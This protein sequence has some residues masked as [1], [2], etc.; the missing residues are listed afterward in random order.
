MAN[1]HSLTDL[2]ELIEIFFNLRNKIFL[3]EGAAY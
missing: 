2:C 1:I 3:E